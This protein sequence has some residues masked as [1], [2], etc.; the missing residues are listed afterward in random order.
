MNIQSVVKT[1]RASDKWKP[2]TAW[3]YLFTIALSVVL[4]GVFAA[5]VRIDVRRLDIRNPNVPGILGLLNS[6]ITP[7]IALI[8]SRVR[9]VKDFQDSFAMIPV[10]RQRVAFAAV[11]GFLIQAVSL[12]VFEGGWKHLRLRTSFDYDALSALLAPFLEEPTGRG[13]L[14]AA[15]R[16]G[17]SVTASTVLVTAV[18]LLNHAPFTFTST[19]WFVLIVSFSV[20]TC[21]LREKTGSLWPP[22]VCHLALNAIPAATQ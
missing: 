14:Y 18:E 11:I 13:F 20:S 6:L 8:F 19:Q 10:T 5:V 17:Y 22:I 15:F 21:I 1:R 2:K 16:K 12:Y 9:T 7:V 3:L 4:L